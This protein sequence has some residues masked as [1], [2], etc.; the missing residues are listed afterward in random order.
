MPRD[1]AGRRFGSRGV[2]RGRA[3]IY[4]APMSIRACLYLLAL[5]ALPLP[6]HAQG[7]GGTDGRK[8][9]V[10]DLMG[11]E[12]SKTNCGSVK[13]WLTK[14]GKLVDTQT[15]QLTAGMTVI[16][17]PGAFDQKWILGGYIVCLDP[18]GPIDG[19]SAFTSSQAVAKVGRLY[20][21]EGP[22]AFGNYDFERNA[23]WFEL[24]R[25]AGGAIVYSIDTE[26][27]LGETSTWNQ[28]YRERVLFL[29][30]HPEARD[31]LRWR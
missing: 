12:I 5:A 16:F 18:N 28:A 7:L 4:A 20:A 22:D 19:V 9:D 2:S 8:A 3:G 14:T 1:L 21:D 25:A 31:D 13:A 30:E 29:N 26:S 24:P 6:A 15:D 10:F 17:G 27:D 23:G 11:L